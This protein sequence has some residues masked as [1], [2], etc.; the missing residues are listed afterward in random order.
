LARVTLLV[1]KRF[2]VGFYFSRAFLVAVATAVLV[3][4]LWEFGRLHGNLMR[5]HRLLVAERETKLMNIEAAVAAIAHQLR[6]PIMGIVSQAAAGRRFLRRER[7][8]LERAQRAFDQIEKAG[9][10]ADHALEGVRVLFK[11]SNADRQMVDLNDVILNVLQL[12]NKE[13]EA[14]DIRINTQLRSPLPAVTGHSAQLREV[15]VNLVQNAIEAM[16][17]V[18]R[19]A[20]ILAISTERHRPNEIVISISDSGPGI[21]ADRATEIFN[22][23]VTTKQHG[24]GFGLAFCKM[25]VEQ[26]GGDISVTSGAGGGAC[27]RIV[28]PGQPAPG[29]G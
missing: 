14:G 16:A 7:P 15:F 26:N 24:M 12:F 9:F 25:V 21:A 19:K 18:D 10:H 17:V 1:S 5:A 20:R 22:P 11:S 4:L 8:E 6:Q 2:T 3:A 13:I 23:F 27:F 28:L 29:M